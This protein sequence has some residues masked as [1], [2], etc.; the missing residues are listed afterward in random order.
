[1]GI[2]SGSFVE[3]WMKAVVI[4]KLYNSYEGKINTNKREELIMNIKERIKTIIEDYSFAK[5]EVEQR[6]RIQRLCTKGSSEVH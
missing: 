3:E 6:N 1:M 2:H 4:W 5:D